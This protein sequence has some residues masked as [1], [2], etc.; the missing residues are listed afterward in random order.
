MFK[1]KMINPQ[2]HLGM[3]FLMARAD[4]YEQ[5]LAKKS[6]SQKVNGSVD[7]T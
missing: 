4:E 6:I 7:N 1:V 3:R 5:D 2:D